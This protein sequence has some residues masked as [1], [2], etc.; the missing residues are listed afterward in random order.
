MTGIFEGLAPH[1]VARIKA[2]ATPVSVPQG[3]S[4]IWE[5]TPADKAYIIETGEV[6]VRRH[7][8]EIAKLGPG[9]IVGETSIVNHTLRTATIVSLSDL[10][11]LHLSRE[12]LERLSAELPAF[13]EALEKAAHDRMSPHPD[14]LQG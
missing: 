8:H 10:K 1:D 9:D 6:S 4:P 5:G 11:L 12:K 7:G 3:W 13:H 14:S 2:M